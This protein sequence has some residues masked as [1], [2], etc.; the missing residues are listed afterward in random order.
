MSDV[1]DLDDSCPTDDCWG[2]V[3]WEEWP[4]EDRIVLIAGQC[5]GCGTL[6]IHC[7]ECVQNTGFH[8]NV[9]HC[10]GCEAVYEELTTN[11]GVFDGVRRVG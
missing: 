4:Q 7:P 10:D 3:S 5:G 2:I 11:D 6:V 8:I 9:Q 1:A